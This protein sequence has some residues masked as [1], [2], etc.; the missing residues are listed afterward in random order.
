ML[1]LILGGYAMKVWE[2]MQK[3]ASCDSNTEVIFEAE[4]QWAEVSE[5]NIEVRNGEDTVVLF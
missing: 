2:L 3:L 4:G 1:E 5:V